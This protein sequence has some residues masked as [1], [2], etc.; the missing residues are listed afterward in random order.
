MNLLRRVIRG[1]Q[2]ARRAGAQGETEPNHKIP[3]SPIA[4]E[5]SGKVAAIPFWFH[6]IDLGM[7]VIT[8]G[9][10]TTEQHRQELAALRIPDLR[11][12][13]VLD[14]GA[15]DGFYSFAAER[16]GAARVVALDHHVWALDREAKAKYKADC[17]AKGV[18]QQH[19]KLEPELWRFDELPGKRGFDL[20]HAVLQSRV[21][22]VVGDLMKMNLEAL[23]RF[24]VVLYLGVL[25]HMENP[26]ESLRRVCQLTKGIAVIETEAIAV[27]GFENTPLCEFFSPRAQLL[28]DPTNF[29][30]PNASALVGLCETA[31][32]NAV[33]LLTTPPTTTGTRIARYRLIAHA[34]V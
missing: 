2:T 12:K 29:W 26:L 7:G 20:A 17:K 32:F 22:A 10:K 4:R 5:L 18:I 13:S 24:D 33:E 19:P 15:W 23:G 28:D 30:A 16:R 1:F 14:I 11:G 25:Y 21:Q 34:H 8:P 31:G 9:T 3:N 27:G 6:S